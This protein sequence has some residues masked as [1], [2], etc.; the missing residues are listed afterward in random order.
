MIIGFWDEILLIKKNSDVGCR[1]DEIW[2]LKDS[3]Q[4]SWSLE[5]A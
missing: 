5:V 1:E 2:R 3:A 4:M